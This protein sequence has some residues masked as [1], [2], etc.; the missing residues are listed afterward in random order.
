MAWARPDTPTEVVDKLNKEINAGLAD[1]KMRARLA[2]FGGTPL[3]V[4][5]ADFGKLIADDTEK[6]GK[7][8]RALNIKAGVRPIRCRY[9]ITSR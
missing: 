8:I 7:V 9:S 1:P 6:W 3:V 5:P 4:S 2:D